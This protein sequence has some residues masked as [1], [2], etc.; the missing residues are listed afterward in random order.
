MATE[1]NNNVPIND[2]EDQKASSR[3]P[4]DTSLGDAALN[5]T[6]KNEQDGEVEAWNRAYDA[7]TPSYELNVDAGIE[8]KKVSEKDGEGNLEK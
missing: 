3:D 5:D 6:E 2:E 8:G 7:S 4:Q 1:D